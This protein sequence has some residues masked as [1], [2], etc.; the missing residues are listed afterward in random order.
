M[1]IQSSIHYPIFKNFRAFREL[2]LNS[3]PIAEAIASREL[4]LPLYPTM[5]FDEVDLVCESLYKILELEI[6]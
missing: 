4:T 1:G 6:I 2:D 3:A 5:S